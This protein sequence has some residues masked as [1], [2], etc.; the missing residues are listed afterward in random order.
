MTV[1]ALSNIALCYHAIATDA[2]DLHRFSS[3]LPDF[4][5]QVSHLR[6]HGYRYVSPS[7]F[8]RWQQGELQTTEPLACLI[9]DDGF[10][11]ITPALWWLVEQAIPFG[12]AIISSRQRK[13]E[14]QDG[15]LSWADLRQ[16]K[17]TGL[18]ELLGHTHN[19]HHMAMARPDEAGEVVSVPV[20]EHPFWLDHGQ[21]LY[22]SAADP[23]WYWELTH[24]EGA[25]AFPLFGTDRQTGQPVQS[26]ISFTADR[27]FD[28]RALRLWACWHQPSGEAYHVGVRIAVDGYEVG[29]ASIRPERWAQ[30][31]WV[32]VD[33]EQP[34]PLEQGGRY[35]LNLTTIIQGNALFRVYAVPGAGDLEMTSTATGHDYPPGV[36]WQARP[37][38]ILCDTTGRLATDAEFAAVLDTDLL[39]MEQAVGRYLNAH[40]SAHSTG[41]V[42]SENL[43]AIVIGGTYANGETADTWIRF[44]P[45]QSF[46]AE[47]LRLQTASARGDW[48]PLVVDIH[49]GRMNGPAAHAEP[50]F[51]GRFTPDWSGWN[52]QEI[53]IAPYPFEAGVDYLLRFTSLTRSAGAMGLVRVLM[54]Q[55]DPSAPRW[56]AAQHDWIMPAADSYRHEAWFTV[57]QPEGS[58]ILPEGVYLEKGDWFWRIR[59][60]YTGS[61]RPF[62]QLMACAPQPE[63]APAIICYPFGSYLSNHYTRGN[64]SAGEHSVASLFEEAL[65]RRGVTAGFSL[66]PVRP[67]RSGL[68]R[69]PALR[70]SQFVI[71]RFMIYGDIP[72]ATVLNHL[73]AYTGLLWEP[74]PDLPVRWQAAVEHDPDGNATVR[75]APIDYVAFDA[76]YFGADDWIHPG[77]IN[78]ADREQVQARG[79]KALLIFSNYADEIGG[80]SSQIAARVLD[81]ADRYIP[82]ILEAVADGWD[83]AAINLEWVPPNRRHNATRFFALLGEQLHARGQLLHLSAPAIS[84]LDADYWPWIG[85]CDYEA[86]LPHVDLMKV[87]TYTVSGEFSRAAAPHAPNW[88]FEAV[89]ERLRTGLPPAYHPKILVGANAFGHRWQ[90]GSVRYVTFHEAVAEA[91]LAGVP[92]ESRDGEGYWRDGDRSCYFGTPET[93]SR[94]VRTAVAFGGVGIWKA[95]DADLVHHFRGT[96]QNI[97]NG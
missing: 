16:F 27:S 43:K 20:L 74:V 13:H 39:A 61:G 89:Y 81:F 18:C 77:P 97:F 35:R 33:L 26:S 12:L 47:T 34:F 23:R 75:Q 7:D 82:Q 93:I 15:F 53:D 32:S 65:Q 44:R 56:D 3:T 46:T 72:L 84:G 51:A 59:A 54:D 85:W 69:E 49:I 95:D 66:Y 86:L 62:L 6:A 67:A 68:V 30:N 29:Y 76:Y 55:A 90:P 88:F 63:P 96:R 94:A 17:A 83:G 8:V 60:P 24:L 41:Y 80:P 5:A 9:F 92:I 70:N 45:Q 4:Q 52:W 87:M 1:K 28:L 21:S 19:L 38:I 79:G 37:C 50:V 10:D 73:D 57:D 31:Q 14:P 42:E 36:P 58:D 25:W 64:V 48:Y 91:I 71:P 2:N 11:S 78:L 22:A 40:W